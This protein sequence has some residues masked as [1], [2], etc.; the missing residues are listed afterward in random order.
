MMK[1]RISYY[2]F[3]VLKFIGLITPFVILI[4]L[5]YNEWFKFS[6]SSGYK[7]SI[8]M[9]LA[10]VV[11]FLMA[12]KRMPK[13]GPLVWSVI[14]AVLF[15]LLEPLM[16]DIKMISWMAVIGTALYS[17][18][19]AISKPLRERLSMEVNANI[20]GKVQEEQTNRIVEAL[21]V[22]GRG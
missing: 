21:R 2:L 8:G 15:T 11:A 16:K 18:F 7:L 10:L 20:N 6:E 22:N 1:T 17:L 14:L 5:N 12:I 4:A 9:I 13:L 3:S 19:D